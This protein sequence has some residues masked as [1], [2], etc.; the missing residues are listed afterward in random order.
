M[1]SPLIELYRNHQTQL[2]LAAPRNRHHQQ[3]Q[4]LKFIYPAIGKSTRRQLHLDTR[5]HL[6]RRHHDNGI[7]VRCLN[8]WI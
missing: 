5:T 7:T 6:M 2:A 8:L 3:R 1:M 4:S